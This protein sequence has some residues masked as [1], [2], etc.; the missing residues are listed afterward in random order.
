MEFIKNNAS[1]LELY[2]SVPRERNKT[3]VF[4]YQSIDLLLSAGSFLNKF[5]RNNESNNRLV[6]L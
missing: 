4:F 1:I 6:I 3:S 2:V 5:E